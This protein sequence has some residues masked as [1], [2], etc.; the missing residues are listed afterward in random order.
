LKLFAKIEENRISTQQQVEM[1]R[2]KFQ[3]ELEK[4]RMEAEAEHRSSTM[5]LEKQ[6]LELNTLQN[7]LLLKA[8]EGMGGSKGD[9][10]TEKRD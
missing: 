10:H 9:T 6:R 7:Q 8:P 2:L 1:A 5:A 4:R 3:E